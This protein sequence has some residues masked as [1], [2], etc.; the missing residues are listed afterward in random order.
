M[1]SKDTFPTPK[2]KAHSVHGGASR[3]RARARRRENQH[4]DRAR[5]KRQIKDT[6]HEGGHRATGRGGGQPRAQEEG[7]HWR[8]ID[9]AGYKKSS[10]RLTMSL[11]CETTHLD[12]VVC[13]LEVRVVEDWGVLMLD[14]RGRIEAHYCRISL[15][16]I[17]IDFESPRTTDRP[18]CP[19]AQTSS[20]SITFLIKISHVHHSTIRIAPATTPS[21]LRNVIH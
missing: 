12:G 11:K 1:P 20:T 13:H 21:N 5:L 18:I 8:R 16:V 6:Y 7:G 4:I 2:A 3:W 19:P 17:L 15:P 9:T 10:G 14:R